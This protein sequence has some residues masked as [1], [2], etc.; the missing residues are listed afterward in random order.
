M[1]GKNLTPQIAPGST[2]GNLGGVL[3][4]PK[5]ADFCIYRTTSRLQ[6][7]VE[8]NQNIKKYKEL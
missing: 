5:N 1:D 3:L 7:I 2:I 8:F 4:P 6:G